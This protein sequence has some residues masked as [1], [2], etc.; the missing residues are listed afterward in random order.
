MHPIEM[1]VTD[2]PAIHNAYQKVSQIVGKD[3][4]YA[5]LN[6]AGIIY[7]V[8]FEFLDEQLARNVMNL[9]VMAPFKI[10]QTFI[11]LLKQH[12]LNNDIKARVINMASWAGYLGQPFI[13]FYNASKAALNGLSESMYYDLGL[14]DIHVVLASPGVTK[15]PLLEKASEDGFQNLMLLS[16]EGRDFYKPYLD[17]LTSMSQ[18]FR[19][20]KYFPTPEITASKIFEIVEAKTPKFKYNL[21]LDAIII[22]RFLTKFIPFCWR[23]ALNKKMFKLTC[24]TL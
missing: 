10:T 9:N 6:N 14:L 19:N 2:G 4:L 7:T 3:G 20:S 24:K 11:P 5:I 23:A 18:N 21:G 13:A 15:T 12:N 17:H 22:D 1:D 8:P 16:K